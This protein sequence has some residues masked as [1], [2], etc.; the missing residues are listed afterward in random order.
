MPPML[1]VESIVMPDDV[2]NM[3]PRLGLLFRQPAEVAAGEGRLDERLEA[4]EF[5]VKM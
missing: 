5:A 3:A 1:Q 4:G 2:C